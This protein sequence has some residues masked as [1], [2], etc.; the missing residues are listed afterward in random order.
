MNLGF[1]K[2]SQNSEINKMI[3]NVT[4]AQEV[5]VKIMQKLLEQGELRGNLN[6]EF[7]E[8][9]HKRMTKVVK[10]I[11]VFD[12]KDTN[13]EEIR[14]YYI[15]NMILYYED[16]NEVS[17]EYLKYGKNKELLAIVQNML[18]L[19]ERE[20]EELKGISKENEV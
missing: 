4:E 19:Q 10:K 7:G 3:Q 9:I 20:I 15:K 11:K 2:Y 6:K 16:T 14:N 17:R 13:F 8:K 1:L 5:K 18:I 12:K